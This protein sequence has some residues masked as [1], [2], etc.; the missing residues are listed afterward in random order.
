MKNKKKKHRY[1]AEYEINASVKMLFPYLST[2]Q[3]LAEWFAE[4]VNIVQ[5]GADKLYDIIWDGESHLAKITAIR[6]NAHVKYVFI[7]EAETDDHNLSFIE[8]K[9]V[10]SDMTDT[11][12]LK[13]IDFSDMDSDTDL[14]ELWGGLVEQLRNNVGA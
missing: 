6:T 13:I 7:D 14:G 12:F 2:P 10:H 5:H 11:S 4:T 3:G 1:I 8:F 9:L